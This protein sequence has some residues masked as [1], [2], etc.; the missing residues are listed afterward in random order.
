MTVSDIELLERMPKAPINHDNKD[1]Y[2]G[3]LDKK[4]LINC[5]DDCG[6]WHRPSCSHCPK[7]WSENITAT[8]VSGNGTVHNLI[9]VHQ[10]APADGVDYSGGYPIATVELDEQEGLRFSSTIINCAREDMRIGMSVKLTWVARNGAP[11]PVFEPAGFE[12]ARG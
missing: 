7:C 2:R 6:I 11:Y 4:L 3:Y 10:G 12:P 9:F 8:Q 1:H 5:C